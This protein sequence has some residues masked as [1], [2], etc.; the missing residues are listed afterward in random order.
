MIKINYCQLKYEKNSIST[1]EDKT[2]ERKA[3]FLNFLSIFN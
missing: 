1:L 3:F 2:K